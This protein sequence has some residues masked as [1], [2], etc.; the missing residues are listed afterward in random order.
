MA[1]NAGQQEAALNGL[2]TGTVTFLFTDIQG[3]THLWQ[4]HPRD[5]K[6]ALAR[7]DALLR[8]AIQSNHGCVFK[9]VGDAFCAAFTT[10]MD[11]VQAALA[12]QLALQ[13]EG[14]PP[15]TPLLARMALHT[16]EAEERDGDFFGPAL[17]RAARLLSIGHGAQTL[18]SLVTAE[19][20]RDTLPE[21]VSLREMGEQRLKDLTRP[22]SVYQLQH[23]ALPADFPPLHS[24]DAHPHNLPVQPTPLIGRE[25]ELAEVEGLIAEGTRVLTLTGPGGMGKT[26]LALQAAADLIERFRYGVFFV[27]LSSL[28]DPALVPARIAQTLRLQEA[29]PRPLQEQLKEFLCQKQIL[30]VLDN[31][32]QVLE[33]ALLVVDLLAS[34][35]NVRFLVTSR[36]ALRV[37]GERV[38]LVPPLGLPASG[39]RHARDLGA[40]GQYEAVRLFIERAAA[41]MPDFQITNANAPAVADVCVRLEGIPLAIELAAA[42]VRLLPPE[43]ILERLGRRLAL[44][45]GGSRDLPQRQQ[46]LRA[47][48]EWSYRLLEE[49]QQGALEVLSVFAGGFAC[50]AAESMLTRLISPELDILGELE[51]LADKSLLAVKQGA[52]GEPRFHILETIREY[53]LEQL[54]GR[55]SLEAARKSSRRLLRRV[56]QANGAALFRPG[57]Q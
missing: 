24:L 5:M 52:A 6:T 13:A 9:T 49:R 21:G 3:S 18:L 53:A 28:T 45:T 10:A 15:A 54:A 41:V 39:K 14:W 27:D 50:A 37:R 43:M 46:T 55:R 26:R 34:C 2:P 35:P 44:L 16:G 47:T 25:K 32:E 20:V 38:F 40:L 42:R 56:E 57:A 23:P 51:A 33:A 29:G 11:G 36:E 30:L 31:F 48:I 22:E 1:Y 12:A 8:E 19:L 7:H 4:D 17:N